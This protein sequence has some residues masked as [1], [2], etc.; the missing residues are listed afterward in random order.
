MEMNRKTRYTLLFTFIV[1]VILCFVSGYMLG[2][3]QPSK[4]TYSSE[5]NEV[6][7]Y[8]DKYYYEEYDKDEFVKGYLKGGVTSLNDPYTYVYFLENNN[9]G[10][11]YTGYGIGTTN[12]GL[13][14][15]VVT[16]YKDSPAGKSGIQA[17]DFITGVDSLTIEDNTCDQI[18]NYLTSAKEEVTLHM[19]RNYKKFDIKI[20]KGEVKANSKTEYN[21]FGSIGYIKINDFNEGSSSSFKSNL[22]ELEK[23]NLTG[24]IIDVR[25][26]PGGDASEVS[27]ILRNFLTGNE[28]F[29]Y[30][31]E[32]DAKTPTI[33]RANNAT[34]K[35]YDIKILINGNSA[36]ASE[37]FAL[38]M[39]RVMNYDLVGTKTF[40]KGVFQQDFELTSIKNGY[41]HI[42]RGYWYGPKINGEREN[43]HK[44]GIEPTIYFDWNSYKA[45]P[46]TS[47]EQ[48][49]NTASDEIKN[50]E[51]M[52]KEMNYDVRIDGYFDDNLK[53]V[54]ETNYESTILDYTTQKKIY[55]EYVLFM[56]DIN[57][58]EAIK[59][60]ISLFE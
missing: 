14:L 6:T 31:D 10:G 46:I 50:I 1:I 41:I 47:D 32:K 59:K 13:G 33:Y 8:L 49:I 42:T 24:L 45:L 22:D 57:N 40:G 9:T 2:H 19:F 58:D 39:N 44:K 25:N 34:K 5:I 56:A 55:D 29:L 20:S 4:L 30:L 3:V 43:I 28:A 36:S 12:T 7:D 60:A 16:V 21:L 15:K 17:D 35:P 26:N 38:C 37:V 53:T 11:N 51:L 54:L 48:M 27:N 52:L 18:S 23:N